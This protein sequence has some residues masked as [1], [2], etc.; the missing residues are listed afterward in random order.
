MKTLTLSLLVIL[1]MLPVAGQTLFKSITINPGLADTTI[2]IG[3]EWRAD[4]ARIAQAASVAAK[5]TVYM[6]PKA[7]I[8]LKIHNDSLFLKQQQLYLGIYATTYFSESATDARVAQL[9]AGGAVILF[10]GTK[11]GTT[12]PVRGYKPPGL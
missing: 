6:F 11:S 12:T 9:R 4:S 3:P 1:V 8:D 2:D 10:M 5:E 7:L